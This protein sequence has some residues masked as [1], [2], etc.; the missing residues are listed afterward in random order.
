MSSDLTVFS[1][2]ALEDRHG[3]PLANCTAMVAT[4]QVYDTDT[5]DWWPL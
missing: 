3:M 5:Y 1:P 4:L 2:V